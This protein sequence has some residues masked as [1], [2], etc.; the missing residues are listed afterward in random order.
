MLFPQTVV[1]ATFS[2]EVSFDLEEMIARVCGESVYL[3]LNQGTTEVY[4]AVGGDRYLHVL[5]DGA[6]VDAQLLNPASIAGLIRSPLTLPGSG[7]LTRG[8]N[9]GNIVA[10][11]YPAIAIPPEVELLDKTFNASLNCMLRSSTPAKASTNPRQKTYQT[12]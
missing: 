6:A 11:E 8:Y 4:E 7:H 3:S 9:A 5:A 2:P 1:S 10:R 12:G